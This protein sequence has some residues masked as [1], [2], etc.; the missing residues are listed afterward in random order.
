MPVTGDEVSR[1]Y[2]QT[3]GSTDIAHDHTVW[4]H[5]S[6]HRIKTT[7]EDIIQAHHGKK[8]ADFITAQPLGAS[9]EGVLH[10]DNLLED[11]DLILSGQQEKVAN[12]SII[13]GLPDFILETFQHG[14]AEQR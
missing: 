13:D 11:A 12:F 10:V 7:G 1:F 3:L 4:V 6:I 5:K 14:K 9:T 8:L 2:T